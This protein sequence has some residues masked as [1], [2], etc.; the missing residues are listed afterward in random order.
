MQNI[1]RLALKDYR[2]EWQNSAC[3]IISLAT[4]L[5]PVLVLFGLKY[6]IVGGMINDL[7]KEPRNREISPISSG[8]YNAA[9]FDSVASRKD[10]EFVIPR[11]RRIAT[12][13]ELKSRHSSQILDIQLVPTAP[14][15]PL[16]PNL[17]ITPGS[18]R[19]LLLSRTIAK[20]LNV[21][22]GDLVSGS[23]ARRYQGNAERIH[24]KLTVQAIVPATLFNQDGAFSSLALLEALENYRDGLAVPGLGWH[25][26]NKREAR[27]YPGFRLF[28]KTINDVAHVRDWFLDI[29]IDVKT[30]AHEIEI[31][32][33]LDHNLSILYWAV[34]VTG[35]GG[36]ILSLSANLWSNIDRKRKELS[37]LRLVGFKSLDIVYFLLVQ[38]F[39]TALAGWLLAIGIYY[40]TSLGI[41]EFMADRLE[42][43]QQVCRL[44]PRHYIISLLATCVS[45]MA[46]AAGAGFKA[47]RVE[48]ADVLREQ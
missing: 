13:I 32:Q 18:Y 8:K 35:L 3:L 20:K 1:A 9:W 17:S 23:I 40:L 4:V 5:G 14:G 19:T 2:Y 24:I 48:T 25:G 7:V 45:V 38:G 11:T 33:R 34:A 39:L 46:V 12:G 31:V 43:G 37:V 22:A 36:C 30:R 42:S 10:V 29:G 21:Q 41:S 26:D 47:A 27:Y 6:G 15:D 44:L 28:T 16:L